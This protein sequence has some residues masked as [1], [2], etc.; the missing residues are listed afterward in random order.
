MAV[1]LSSPRRNAH[2]NP[3]PQTFQT[4]SRYSTFLSTLRHNPQFLTIFFQAPSTHPSGSSLLKPGHSPQ[5]GSPIAEHPPMT[6]KLGFIPR[7]RSMNP[8]VAS[9]PPASTPQSHTPEH[10]A[11]AGPAAKASKHPSGPLHDLRRFLNNHV[12]HHHSQHHLAAPSTTAD[13]LQITI[14]SPAEPSNSSADPPH[15]PD[16]ESYNSSDR[17]NTP[18][19]RPSSQ[20]STGPPSPPGLNHTPD[21]PHAQIQEGKVHKEHILAAFM[22]K[23]KLHHDKDKIVKTTKD[24][25]TNRSP[26]PSYS[27]H[28]CGPQSQLPV[29]DSHP[30]TSARHS[31]SSTPSRPHPI[32]SLSEATQA[33]LSKKYGKWGRVLGSGAG[34]TVRLIKASNK[35]GGHIFAVKEFRPRR[36]G[37]SEKE[38]QKKVTAEFCVGS[39]LKHP[40]IIETVDIVCDHGHYYEVALLINFKCTLISLFP[41]H[42][43]SWNM[44]RT[45]SSASSCPAKCV[46]PRFIA[47][48]DK[49]ATASSI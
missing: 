22:R 34:G 7:R 28:S 36:T 39:T 38:Y 8:L 19:T 20:P 9:T 10:S 49:S 5:Q 12:V 25:S 4:R 1:H 32:N 14:H 23:D 26:S 42:F 16:S 30:S 37:E 6:T 24:R 27:S 44:P 13:Q 40:N 41:L 31:G 43:R 46:G 29:P 45:T 18:S 17:A 33:H 48:S 21:L 2:N 3:L 15:F 35:N 11:A 47:C